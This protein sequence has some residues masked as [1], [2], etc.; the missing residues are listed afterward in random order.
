MRIE[1]CISLRERERER[2]RERIDKCVQIK[3]LD[4]TVAWILGSIQ[5]HGTEHLHE[6]G[7]VNNNYIITYIHSLWPMGFGNSRSTSHNVTLKYEPLYYS[8]TTSYRNTCSFHYKKRI[9][10]GEFDARIWEWESLMIK[11]E[12]KEKEERK[13]K[14]KKICMH[15][16]PS[17]FPFCAFFFKKL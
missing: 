1:V 16:G 14:W 4:V 11:W 3:C 5:I 7:G 10:K 15:K 8:S 6:Y 9:E 12:E 13:R 17:S 2:E